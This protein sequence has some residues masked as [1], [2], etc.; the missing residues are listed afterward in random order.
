DPFGNYVARLVFPDRATAFSVEVDLIA[1]MT[2]INPFDFFVEDAAQQFPF[3][4]DEQLAVDLTPYLEVKERG[5]LLARWLDR[6]PRTARNTV[7]FLVEL[8]QRLQSD[9]GYVVRFEPGV[10]TCEQTLSLA[11]GS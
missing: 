10:Q 7:D 9:I 2:V 3:R 5:P 1:D 8:N 11:R 4:Y 6:V